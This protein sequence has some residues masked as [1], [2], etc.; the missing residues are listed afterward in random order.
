M[1][2]FISKVIHNIPRSIPILFTDPITIILKFLL[3]CTTP[4]NTKL[5]NRIINA[6]F[7]LIYIQSMMK[8]LFLVSGSRLKK[9]FNETPKVCI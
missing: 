1:K 2:I 5:F 8:I 4:L 3:N 9:L 7:N 6:V